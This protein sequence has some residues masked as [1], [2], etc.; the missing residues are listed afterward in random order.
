MSHESVRQ[1]CAAVAR[2]HGLTARETEVL[3][4]LARGRDVGYI[5]GQL[6]ITRNTANAHRKN[7]YS[8]LGIHSQQELLTAV[9][10]AQ[11]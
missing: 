8:K 7:I 2:E 6:S 11:V 3:T 4:L 10:E 5:C 1:R 9:E